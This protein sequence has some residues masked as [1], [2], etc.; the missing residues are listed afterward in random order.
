M[1]SEA[2]PR[3]LDAGDC[4]LVV[5][6]GVGIDE[7]VNARVLGLDAALAADPVD[8]IRET[9]PTYRSLLIIHDPRRL[10]RHA[11]KD[12]ISALLAAGI[13][14]TSG[15]L[16]RSWR[17]PVC[18]GGACGEDL[19]TVAAQHG[20]TTDDVIRLH[21][22]ALYRV[23]MIGFM[24]GFS[25]LGGLPEAIHTSR[26]TVPRQKT[27][28]RSISIGGK[29]AAVSP[30][31]AIPSAWQ[32]LGQTSVRVYD[33]RREAMPFLLSTGDTVRFEP[34]PPAEYERLC[35]MEESGQI[36]AKLEETT[37]RG[38]GRATDGKTTEAP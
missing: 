23:Y 31:M 9:V 20:L 3:F 34:V 12:R 32:M 5:E 28:P 29:Q 37:E 26:R 2:W 14:R 16:G 24:P 19:D 8:G 27:P 7:A 13:E 38:G 15:A 22:G 1:H 33:P 30:P 21:S 17:I 6:F 36:T 4:G 10:R 18:Y 35:D 25:Y 11:L